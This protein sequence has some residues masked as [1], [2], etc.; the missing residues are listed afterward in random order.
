MKRRFLPI[1]LAVLLSGCHNVTTHS[2]LTDLPGAP[3]APTPAASGLAPRP[4]APAMP[5]SA[6]QGFTGAAAAPA[7]IVVRLAEGTD[8]DAFLRRPALAGYRQQARLSLLGR[9]ALE[10]F[11]PQGLS[12]EAAIAALSPL[13]GV[14]GAEP[15]GHVAPASFAFASQDPYYP[16]QWAHQAAFADT[17][18][19]WEKVPVA[20]QAKVVIAVLDTGCDV[21]HPEFAGR[22]VGAIDETFSGATPGDVTDLVGH[23]THVMGIAGATGNNGQGVAGVAWGA[24]L[25]PIKV[26]TPAGGSDFEIVS[27]IMDAIHFRPSPDDGSRVRVINM[28]LGASIAGA[29]QLYADALKEADAA[30]VVVAIAAGNDG[31]DVVESP[32]NT[33]L[34]IAVGATEHYLGWETLADYSNHGDRLDLCA[35]GTDIQSTFPLSGAAEGASYG[36]ISGTSMATPYVTGVA[37]LVAARYDKDNQHLTAAYAALI[38]NRLKTAV[39]DLGVPGPDPV[40]GTGRLNAAKAVTPAALD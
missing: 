29:S 26:L 25:L 31:L 40:Y 1:W 4:A 28:S 36:A 38:R 24:K 37:A 12:R 13:D 2:Y 6:T 34:A 3:P 14:L 21:T 17:V 39:D 27:G 22:I 33:P 10:V 35:P 19:A 20:D 32:A 15:N 7:S 30:G 11:P 8:P 9:A 5:V 18:D 16:Q 23:G